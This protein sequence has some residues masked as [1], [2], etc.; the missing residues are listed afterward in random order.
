MIFLLHLITI[1]L[2]YI[3]LALSYLGIGWFFSRIL[4]VD[5][6]S[7]NKLFPLVWVGWVITLLLLQVLN[8]FF[9]IS[10]YLSIPFLV[11][12]LICAIVFF[13]TGSEN[14]AIYP[15]SRTYLVFLIVA[16]LWVAALSMQTPVAY[17]SGLYH[18]NSVRWLNEF[19]I[20]LGLG[21]LHGRLAFNQ[22]FF[23]YVAYLNVYPLFKHGH[24][25]ANSFLLLTLSAESLLYLSKCLS[26]KAHNANLS[27]ADVVPIL[28]LPAIAYLAA[29]GDLSSPTPDTAASILQILIF[30]YFVRAIDEKRSTPN[31]IA[32]MIFILVVSATLMTIKLSS[33][34]FVLS[35]CIILFLIKRQSFSISQ[36]QLPRLLTKL[37]SVPILIIS[38]W[39]LR[40]IL[41]SGCPAYPSTAGCI[42]AH[43]SV[44][45]AS[46]KNEAAWIYSW[47]RAPK[48]TPAKVLNSWN[49]L[50]PWF[51]RVI[52]GNK[53]TVVYPLLIFTAGIITG[54]VS[55]ARQPSFQKTNRIWFLVFTPVL[56][57]L[58]F[59]FCLA[60]GIRFAHSLF[61]IAPVA[62][63]IITLRVLESAGKLETKNVLVIFFIINANIGLL[64]AWYPQVF[65]NISKA[66][67]LPI[68]VAVLTERTTLSGLK[69]LSPLEPYDQCWDSEIPCTPY[70][71]ANLNFIERDIFSEFTIN[72]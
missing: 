38:I 12:G 36:K 46:V 11:F 68:P 6:S 64:F 58:L 13:K 7:E 50:V 70:F 44:P 31:D 34:F 17:D 5:F 69:V 19:P 4:R 61:W 20:V 27:T 71:N 3:I 65:L 62:A 30:I 72:K 10:A 42:N 29:Y 56:I 55:Y 59:W 22:S 48:Q 37:I 63:T 25:I 57:G 18:F 35:I 43:W 32:Q 39:S 51:Y 2:A 49:W 47:A 14:K 9:P 26:S 54:F 53:F 52:W 45:I 1:V 60:P 41:L 24:N 23:V 21:N 8:L 66:G 16:V 33:S 15:L 40:G 28:F 67:I